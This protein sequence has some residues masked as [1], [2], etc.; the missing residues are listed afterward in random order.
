MGMNPAAPKGGTG[1]AVRRREI[2]DLL[3]SR[4]ESRLEEGQT[5][6][7]FVV[8]DLAR[9]IGMSRSAFYLYYDDRGDFL[10]AITE[11]VM[12]EILTATDAWWSMPPDA[13]E[14]D[15]R[16]VLRTIFAAYLPRRTVMS[17]F[18][19]AAGYEPTLR[20]TYRQLLERAIGQLATHIR[21][22]QAAGT[23]RE[24]VQAEGVATWLIL[25]MERSLSKS[26]GLTD[27]TDSTVLTAVTHI[28]WN[29]LYAG[30]RA[31]V[32]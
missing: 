21:E 5:F 26:A 29:T 19:E 25:L 20:D 22:G 15:L 3:L 1:R 10:R 4:V 9:E 31:A 27:A 7:D 14:D 30:R 8:E 17:A 32:S 6:R 23:V 13:T 12:S 24:D 16:A 2:S 28:V 11:G 18:V